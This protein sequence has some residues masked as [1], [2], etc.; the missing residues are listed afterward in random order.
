M[1]PRARA[2]DRPR[3]SRWSHS[4]HRDAVLVGRQ[5]GRDLRVDDRPAEDVDEVEERQEEARQH[6][7]RVELDDRLA[8]H[9][10][11]DDQHHRRRDQDAEGAAGGD[12]AGGQPHVVAGVQHRPQR[13]DAHEDHHRADDAGGDA[14]ER[15]H[16]ERGHRQRGGHAPE[17]E[18]HAVEHPVHQRRPLHDVAH[19]DEQRDR[20]QRVVGH[21]PVGPLHDQV[22]DPVVVPVLARGPEGEEAEDHA[23]AHQ[24]EGGREAHHDRDHDEPQHGEAE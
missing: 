1:R 21:H 17:G 14:P 9:R 23:Q 8:G 19:E 4:G 5:L 6:R 2:R 24:R 16:Q 15:A 12:G 7:R 13:D 18:L 20:Q 22:E 11:V 10:R 3:S